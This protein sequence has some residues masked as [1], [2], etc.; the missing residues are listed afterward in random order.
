[1]TQQAGQKFQISDLQ[2]VRLEPGDVLVV[3]LKMPMTDA[4]MGRFHGRLK[5]VFPDNDIVIV[6]GNGVEFSIIEQGGAN[7]GT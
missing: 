7:D 2:R 6:D 1:M 4:D 3:G 5:P